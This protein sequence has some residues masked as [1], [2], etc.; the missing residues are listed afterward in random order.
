MHAVRHLVCNLTDTRIPVAFIIDTA[1]VGGFAILVKQ[2]FHFGHSLLVCIQITTQN[3]Y[4]LHILI[5][6]G[7]KKLKLVAVSRQTPLDVR[8]LLRKSQSYIILQCQH[9][10][11]D[12]IPAD[13]DVVVTI[14]AV[15]AIDSHARVLGRQGSQ[16]RSRRSVLIFLILVHTAL[17]L[18]PL[19]S[20]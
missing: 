16:L 1:G 6:S 12:A 5:N 14:T 8:G 11:G 18:K 3:G 4:V 17:S 9:V 20:L 2:G 10:P 7:T 15:Y 13:D 19:D